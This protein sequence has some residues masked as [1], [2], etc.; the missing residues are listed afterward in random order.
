MYKSHYLT[1]NHSNIVAVGNND[2]NNSNILLLLL[3]LLLLPAYE[4]RN[5]GFEPT[6]EAVY[7]GRGFS[8]CS[9][10]LRTNSEAVLQN[11]PRPF[12]STYFP[13]NLLQKSSYSMLY[14]LSR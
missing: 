5:H 3:L 1:N 7:P 12:P 6:P 9:Q 2:I 8:W 13:I 4:S 11:R 14:N 10:I